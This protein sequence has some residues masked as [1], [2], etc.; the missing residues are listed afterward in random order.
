MYLATRYNTG[1]EVCMSTSRQSSSFD[2]QPTSFRLTPA[3]K[4]TLERLAKRFDLSYAA[5]VTLALREL[6][7][8]ANAM[9]PL[10]P[11][12]VAREHGEQ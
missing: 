9:P 4:A 5:I 7:E 11:A 10:D 8:R 6:E 12:V 2:R 1:M 3:T